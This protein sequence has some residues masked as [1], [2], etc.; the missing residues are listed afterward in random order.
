MAKGPREVMID[1]VRYVPAIEASGDV[2][3][4]IARALVA[5]WLGKT[6][7]ADVRECAPYL[8]VAVTDTGDDGVPFDVFMAELATQLNRKDS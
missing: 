3:K 5:T 7:D 6:T 8:R 2:G 4:A 1:G